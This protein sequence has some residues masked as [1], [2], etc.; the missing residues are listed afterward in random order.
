MNAKT[1]PSLN[2][3]S[4]GLSNGPQKIAVGAG[5]LKSHPLGVREEKR[6][7]A[8]RRILVAVVIVALS[9]SARRGKEHEDGL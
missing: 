8:L 4:G 7:E 9:D 3:G 2:G 6:K 1:N 5:G